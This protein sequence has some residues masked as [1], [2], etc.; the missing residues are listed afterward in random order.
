MIMLVG[1][2]AAAD[3]K[4]VHSTVWEAHTKWKNIGIEL[5]LL[6]TDL[7]EIKMKNG[8]DVSDCSTEMLSLWLKQVNPR[9]AMINALSQPAVG[10]QQL[11][12]SINSM[13]C[14]SKSVKSG[15]G[16]EPEMLSFPHIK[17]VAPDERTP[18]LLE[19]RLR[20]ESLDI[21]QDF[22]ALVNKLF[23]SLEEQDYSVIKVVG[24]LKGAVQGDLHQLKSMED[25]KLRIYTK[26]V[27][28]FQLSSG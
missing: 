23:D 24:Y 3:L 27:F 25:V 15:L 28:L 1:Q 12:E 26:E 10:L 20:E 9:S 22:L 18:Q 8:E 17:S 16:F 11:A 6:V 7:D 2:L 13:K 4:V 21:M 19:G 5:D 14:N